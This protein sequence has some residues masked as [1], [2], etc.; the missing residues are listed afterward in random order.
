[1]GMYHDDIAGAVV[2]YH[3][4]FLWRIKI[5]SLKNNICSVNTIFLFLAPKIVMLVDV[6]FFLYMNYHVSNRIFEM[7]VA[8]YH[9]SEDIAFGII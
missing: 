5:W 8:W 7:W 1:M 9:L 6:N 3:Q 2:S 4:I